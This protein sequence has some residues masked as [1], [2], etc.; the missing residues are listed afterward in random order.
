M[1]LQLKINVGKTI[2]FSYSNYE[3]AEREIKR[4]PFHIEHKNVKF[5][6]VNLAKEFKIVCSDSCKTEMKEIKMIENNAPCLWIGRNNLMKKLCLPSIAEC[7]FYQKNNSILY[8]IR[9]IHMNS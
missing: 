2:C 4:H 6:G 9:K 1:K 8:R 7:N 3:I 5:L